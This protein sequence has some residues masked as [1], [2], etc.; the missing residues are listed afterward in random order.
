MRVLDIATVICQ[1][2][3]IFTYFCTVSLNHVD[4]LEQF[5]TA[6]CWAYAATELIMLICKVFT[7][8]SK[9]Y[10]YTVSVKNCGVFIVSQWCVLMPTLSLRTVHVVSKITARNWMFCVACVGGA[11]I[12]YC[13]IQYRIREFWDARTWKVVSYLVHIEF[14]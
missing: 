8:L 2:L 10:P 14:I 9:F 13:A 12:I 7:I 6:K 4:N 5:G 1:V 11:A 3:C